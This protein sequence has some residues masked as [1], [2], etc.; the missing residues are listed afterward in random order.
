MRKRTLTSNSAYFRKEFHLF[1]I[2]QFHY[3]EVIVRLDA[4]NDLTLS[5]TR[6]LGV[7]I[8]QP[9][10]LDVDPIEHPTVHEL[11]MTGTPFLKF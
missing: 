5:A 3:Y 9:F 1:Y 4:R 6:S 8:I 11:C 7:P 10:L 2:I